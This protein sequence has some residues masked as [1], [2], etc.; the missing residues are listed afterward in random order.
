[1]VQKKVIVDNKWITQEMYACTHCSLMWKIS[2]V[3]DAKS[4]NTKILLPNG[5]KVSNEEL[6]KLWIYN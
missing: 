1:M 4:K 5:K 2:L 6:E 3:Y